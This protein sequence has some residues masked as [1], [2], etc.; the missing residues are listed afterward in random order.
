MTIDDLEDDPNDI[1]PQVSQHVPSYRF[2]QFIS[3]MFLSKDE[4][5][6]LESIRIKPQELVDSFIDSRWYYNRLMLHST[7][8]QGKLN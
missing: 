8:I 2:G 4:E 6:Y 3:K 1:A 5:R 7:F